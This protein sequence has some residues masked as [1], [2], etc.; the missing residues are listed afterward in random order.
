MTKQDKKRQHLLNIIKDFL[1]TSKSLL[2]YYKFSADTKKAKLICNRSLKS[3]EKALVSVNEIKHIEILEYLYSAFIGNNAIVYS[4]SGNFINSKKMKHYDTDKGFKEF[5]D[6]I[7]EQKKLEQEREQKRKESE[8]A[9]KKA[10]ELGKKVE[11]VYDNG[12]KSV[13]PMVVEEKPNA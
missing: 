3:I 10:K 9:I 1:K 12:T 11:M 7:E 13:K 4:V 6:F 2:E 5:M 8:E